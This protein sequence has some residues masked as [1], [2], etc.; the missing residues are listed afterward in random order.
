[1]ALPGTVSAAFSL[2]LY[3]S[4]RIVRWISVRELVQMWEGRFPGVTTLDTEAAAEGQAESQ[5]RG[6]SKRLHWW[7]LEGGK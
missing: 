5:M 1:M 3:S 4:A 2:P 6:Y 7:E